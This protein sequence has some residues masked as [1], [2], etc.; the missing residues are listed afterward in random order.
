MLFHVP[1][2]PAVF[3]ILSHL[4]YF[5]DSFVGSPAVPFDQMCQKQHESPCTQF[6]YLPVEEGDF[7]NL[8]RF[9]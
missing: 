1:I 5:Q 3:D 8:V 9:F 6:S 7:E 2:K 4:L